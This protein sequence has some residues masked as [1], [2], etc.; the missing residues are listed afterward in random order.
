MGMGIKPLCLSLAIWPFARCHFVI[1]VRLVSL[2][3]GKYANCVRAHNDKWNMFWKCCT[4]IPRTM[5]LW[6]KR[7]VQKCEYG[8]S[9]VKKEL[10]ESLQ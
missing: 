2:R 9:E 5:V 6:M 7:N 3:W 8:I 1:I 4:I 10:L